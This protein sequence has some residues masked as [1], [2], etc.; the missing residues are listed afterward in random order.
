MTAHPANFT[1]NGDVIDHQHIVKLAVVTGTDWVGWLT[2]KSVILGRRRISLLLFS[3]RS[4]GAE[5][6]PRL[7]I[8][9]NRRP[10][11]Q[12][13]RSD[14]L[15]FK[16]R[17]KPH[18]FILLVMQPGVTSFCLWMTIEIKHLDIAFPNGLP[19]YCFMHGNRLA[20]D[21]IAIK[22]LS[23]RYLKQR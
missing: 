12:F 22:R 16:H 6:W 17:Y 4:M 2:I 1:T 21:N 19:I 20:M 3:G 7:D 10:D 8:K 23:Y 13:R 11:G 9:E 18:G 5:V 15:L 14:T